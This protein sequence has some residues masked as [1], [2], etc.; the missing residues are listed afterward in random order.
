M[1]YLTKKKG[2]L[3]MQL[4]FLFSYS[5]LYKLAEQLNLPLLF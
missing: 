2:Q 3:Q 5:L 4:A 1:L